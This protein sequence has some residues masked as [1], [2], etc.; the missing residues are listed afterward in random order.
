MGQRLSFNRSCV[1][2]SA[3]WCGSCAGIIGDPK[4]EAPL[5]TPTASRSRSQT[6]TTA[7]SAGPQGAS[8]PDAPG[9]TTVPAAASNPDRDAPPV[10]PAVPDPEHDAPPAARAE[11]AWLCDRVLDDFSADAAGAFPSSW[12]TPNKDDLA[13]VKQSGTFQVEQDA[14]KHVLHARFR[15]E[16]V[17]LG[18]GVRDWDLTRYPVLQWRWKAVALPRQASELD[19]A[20]DD[21]AASVQAVWLV[22]FP[23]MVRLLKYT[24]SSTLAT[25]THASNRLG[26]DQLVVLES[27]SRHLGTWQTER[28][29]IREHYQQLFD[30]KD[31][32]PP[33]GISIQTDADATASQADAYYADFRLCRPTGS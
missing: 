28:V 11:D 20:R 23:F 30:L 5:P 16:A 9:E 18:R 8:T 27:G 33:T 4:L 31:T 29:N 25:G 21:T 10:A 22:G 3:L 15:G 7:A 17:S 24:W 26:H 2:L 6:L 13:R 12:E 19:S 32:T 1:V 14:G